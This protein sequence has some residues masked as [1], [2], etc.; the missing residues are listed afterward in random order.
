V[1]VRGGVGSEWFGHENYI[2]SEIFGLGLYE[3]IGSGLNS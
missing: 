3:T 2:L 1:V